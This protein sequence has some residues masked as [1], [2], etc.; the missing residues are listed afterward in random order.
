MRHDYHD[1]V[2]LELAR[3]IASRLC[4]DPTLIDLARANLDRWS[5]N[6]KNASG[7]LRCYDEW[8][9][10][11][12]QPLDQIIATLTAETDESQRL[13]QNSPFTGILTQ[14]EVLEIKRRL[15]DDTRAA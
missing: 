11:L 7:L 8:R 15:R 13:R 2:S 14:D 6:N 3:R 4:A 10:I 5:E 12:D 1:R 9:Q